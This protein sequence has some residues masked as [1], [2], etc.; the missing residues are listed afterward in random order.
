[1]TSPMVTH[2][3]PMSAHYKSMPPRPGETSFSQNRNQDSKHE[4]PQRCSAPQYYYHTN[5]AT[6]A[7]A[8]IITPGVHLTYVP[9][10]TGTRPPRPE[11]TVPNFQTD[12]DNGQSRSRSRSRS[13]SLTP[14]AITFFLRTTSFGKDNAQGLAHKT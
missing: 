2:P 4:K 3:R 6:N 5:A 12:Q 13:W 11:V 7:I 10:G 1:M 8:G 14:T 9:P